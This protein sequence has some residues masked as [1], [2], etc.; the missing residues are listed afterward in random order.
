MTIFKEYGHPYSLS[1]AKDQNETI[2]IHSHYVDNF[3]LYASNIT[4]QLII[5]ELKKQDADIHLWQEIGL[6]WQKVDKYDSCQ[7]RTKG[8]ELLLNL[9]CNTTELEHS[10]P[11]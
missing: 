10:L 6:Y 5:N 3:P 4:N 8:L 9:T 11:Y 7:S 1:S 2:R